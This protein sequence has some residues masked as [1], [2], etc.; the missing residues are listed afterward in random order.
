MKHTLL[1]RMR[2]QY[3][4]K[5]KRKGGVRNKKVVV[6]NINVGYTLIQNPFYPLS[7]S[8]IYVNKGIRIG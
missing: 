2:Q 6:V 8:K 1:K 7:P 3:L 4:Y 5:R